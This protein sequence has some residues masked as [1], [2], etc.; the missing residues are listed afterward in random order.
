MTVGYHLHFEPNLC[1]MHQTSFP[2]PTKP[3]RTHHWF[4]SITCHDFPSQKLWPHMCAYLTFAHRFAANEA[5]HRFR[6]IRR[7]L[8]VGYNPHGDICIGH[9]GHGWDDYGDFSEAPVCKVMHTLSRG[10]PLTFFIS[11]KLNK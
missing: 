4:G 7:E 11:I 2:P 10:V 3:T 1:L 8:L 5:I 9:L 6:G